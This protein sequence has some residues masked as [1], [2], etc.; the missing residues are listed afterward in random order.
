MK[1][2]LSLLL[3]LV[4]IFASLTAMPVTSRAAAPD[5]NKAG[6]T[7]TYELWVA[8]TQVTA[9][10]AADLSVIDGVD[11]HVSFDPSTNTLTLEDATIINKHPETTEAILYFGIKTRLVLNIVAKGTNEVRAKEGVRESAGI[12]AEG[13]SI[14][15]IDGASLSAYGS[16]RLRGN[17]TDLSS[18]RSCGIMAHYEAIDIKGSGTLLAVGGNMDSNSYDS[19]SIGIAYGGDRCLID[20]NVDVTAIGGNVEN[21]WSFGADVDDFEIK[22]GSFTAI[23]GVGDQYGIALRAPSITITGG[24]L[25]AKTKSTGVGSAALSCI[26]T[27]PSGCKAIA[28]KNG[29]GSD[30]EEYNADSNDSYKYFYTHIHA[31][32]KVPAKPAEVGVAG[33]I[34]YY[35]CSCGK[36]FADAEGKKEI[37]DKNSVIIP[38]LE[39]PDDAM[40]TVAYIEKLIKKTN[41]NKKDVTG[42]E[43]QTLKLQATA[44]KN[45]VTLKWQHVEN[46]DGYII[47]GAPY[48]KKM[49]KISVIKNPKT[50][51]GKLRKQKKGKYYKYII[52]AYKK[53]AGGNKVVSFSKTIQCIT[54][55]A[56]YGNP[57][58]IKIKKTK[59]KLRTGKTLKL[60]PKMISKK[61]VALHL[62]KFRFESSDES[63]AKVDKNGKIKAIAKGKATIYIYLQNGLSKKITVTVT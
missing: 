26:P 23:A 42:S 62:T 31:L 9:A 56:K 19:I 10:N 59:I 27:M 33:N 24:T 48:G 53:S 11:G 50:T 44:K 4:M 46:A 5:H 14:N 40:L 17:S 60:K 54:D 30:S 25:E 57:T 63:V 3:S 18:G 45:K 2:K 13:L 8:G 37:K 41:T 7:Q 36:Y 47:Y 51:S 21:G 32:T 34:E 55:G 38:P 12:S 28:S 29:D 16:N 20:G 22:S 58:G 49:S 6:D 43:Y 61:K 52:V 35:I 1:K 39:N 15:L